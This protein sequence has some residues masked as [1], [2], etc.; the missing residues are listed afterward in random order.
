MKRSFI[1]ISIHA[2]ARGATLNVFA[3]S[4]AFL[5]FNP[6]SREG[7]DERFAWRWS[8]DVKYFNPR[9]REGSDLNCKARQYLQ[10]ISIHAPA[11]GATNTGLFDELKGNISIHAPARGATSTMDLQAMS[12]VFQSTLPRG[13]RHN[14]D[15][16]KSSFFNF[17]PRSREGSDYEPATANTYSYV[18]SIHAPARGATAIFTKEIYLFFFKIV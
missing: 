11:R 8:E 2:P 10:Y 4:L 6:R 3:H 7:S 18:I 15:T 9:S 13:E 16:K 12:K 17:N 14:V 1:K 5:D